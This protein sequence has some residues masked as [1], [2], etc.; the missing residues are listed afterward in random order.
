MRVVEASVYGLQEVRGLSIL[1]VLG[2]AL[3]EETTCDLADDKKC[4]LRTFIL[5]SY[6][7]LKLTNSTCN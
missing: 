2:N 4:H 3:A 1:A 5:V 7:L 6:A